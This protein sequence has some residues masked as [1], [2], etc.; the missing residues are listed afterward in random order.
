ML[1]LEAGRAAD[2]AA[3][4]PARRAGGDG[5]RGPARRARELFEVERRRRERLL[6]AFESPG[7][8]GAGRFGSGSAPE[9]RGAPDGARAGVRAILPAGG[10]AVR[11]ST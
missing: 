7:E 9:G 2:R 3:D 8:G 10:E 4:P 6:A 5:A 11:G 1:L